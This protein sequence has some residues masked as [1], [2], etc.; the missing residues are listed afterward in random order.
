MS[1]LYRIGIALVRLQP[2]ASPWHQLGIA[3]VSPWHPLVLFGRSIRP[4]IIWAP[5]WHH[6]DIHLGT[7]LS[8]SSMAH[9]QPTYLIG[10][11][12]TYEGRERRNGVY[13]VYRCTVAGC[14]DLRIWW[15]D[16]S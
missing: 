7:I 12:V 15:V 16:A 8:T 14:V 6:L 10:T 2:L 9:V 3:L 11:E 4:G 13:N 1:P 5:F